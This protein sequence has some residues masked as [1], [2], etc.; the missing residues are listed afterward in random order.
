ML[1]F[2]VARLRN[3]LSR[4]NSIGIDAVRKERPM[5]VRAITLLQHWDAKM[6]D[7]SI[8]AALAYFAFGNL[9]E[10]SRNEKFYDLCGDTDEFSW[11]SLDQLDL[12]PEQLL[13]SIEMA[14]A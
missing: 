4:V 1:S 6:S 9:L 7:H 2:A 14:G 12:T 10:G 13:D 5:L 3:F 11:P 8:A